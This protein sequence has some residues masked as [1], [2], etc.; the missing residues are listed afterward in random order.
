MDPLNQIAKRKLKAGLWGSE[1]FIQRHLY[2]NRP[3]QVGWITAE[4]LDPGRSAR[5]VERLGKLGSVADMRISNNA[6]WMNANWPLG[7]H[8]M[9]DA[10]RHYDIVVFVKAM[11]QTCQ[12]EA[13]KIKAYGGTIVFDSNVNYYEIWGT[14]PVPGTQP[15]PRQQQDAIQMSA[16]A[17]WIVA[18]SSYIMGISKKYNPNTTWVPDNVNLDTFRGLR[19]HRKR[20]TLYLVW[21]GVSKKSYH[22]LQVKEVLQQLSSVELVLVSDTVPDAMPELQKVIPCHYIE[23]SNERYVKALMKSDIIISPKHLSNS[24]EMGHTEYKITLGM[25]IGL[26]A[27]ASPQRSYVEAINYAHGGIIADTPEDWLEALT[28][29]IGDPELRTRMGA[30]AQQTVRDRYSTPVVA[31][32][33]MEVLKT[34]YETK[35]HL[36]TPRLPDIHRFRASQVL[37]RDIVSR[38]LKPY[39]RLILLADSPHWSI[40]EDM[41]QIQRIAEKIGIKSHTSHWM[42]NLRHQAIFYGSQFALLDQELLREDQRVAIAY[43]HGKPGDGLEEFDICYKT[44]CEHHEKIV[45]VQV[46]NEDMKNLVLESGIDPGKVFL[47]RIGIDT[48]HFARQTYD[49]KLKVRDNLGIPA[50]AVVVG[51]FQKD[52]IGWGEGNDPKLIKGPDVFL[53]TIARLKKH[54]PKIHVLLSGPARGYVK[55]GLDE[56]GVPYV[57]RYLENS[58]DIGTLFQ[59]LDVY[60][61]SSRVEGG[62]KA[63]LESMASGVPLVTTRVGQAADIVVNGEN[64]W[65][66]ESEDVTGLVEAA[67]D[68][69][70]DPDS[71]KPIIEN[72]LELAAE[73]AYDSLLPQWDKFFDGWIARSNA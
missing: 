41:K 58:S 29:L 8:E 27:V 17:D 7:W 44:L 2:G 32:Q 19:A 38:A 13:Q 47:I 5:R 24:Y 52:G 69:L 22:L 59:A 67:I 66:V 15:T 25:A 35:E 48:T 18:D 23:Y 70:D 43:F 55:R 54:I 34:L 53:E 37:A 11:D 28:S 14:Y 16:L 10:S 4:T 62:P 42:R 51:S 1:R 50:D 3:I 61:V 49:S 73:N 21:S 72:A 46:S 60:I 56:I 31:R 6:L 45:R 40:S 63:I 39:S 26:P 65:M 64:G 30:N 36:R 9:Y 71:N 20:E 68:A 33:Y 12:D 57:H